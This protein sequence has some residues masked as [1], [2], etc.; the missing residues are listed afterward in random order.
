MVVLDTAEDWQWWRFG[1]DVVAEGVESETQRR[2]LAE[3]GCSLGQGF[4]FSK[5]ISAESIK[6]LISEIEKDSNSLV[7][8]S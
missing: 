3:M 2:M 1:I 5:P 7:G 4:L 8:Q 6:K